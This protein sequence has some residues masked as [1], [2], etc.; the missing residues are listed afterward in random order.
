MRRSL[1]LSLGIHGFIVDPLVGEFSLFVVP[2]S[3]RYGYADGSSISSTSW[4][5]GGNLIL[6]PRGTYRLFLGLSQ[7]MYDTSRITSEDPTALSRAPDHNTTM[8][9]RFSIHGGALRG[10]ALMASRN[11]LEFVDSSIDSRI[12]ETQ[13][14]SWNRASLDFK[15]R[16]VLT[17]RQNDYGT[18]SF[19]SEDLILT[20][21]ENG[22][23]GR[24]WTWDGSLVGRE[25]ST[26]TGSDA[27]SY[28]TARLFNRFVKRY[29]QR[30]STLRISQSY[31]GNQP[32]ATTTTH[33][34]G[35]SVGYQTPISRAFTVAAGGGYST[36]LGGKS[37]LRAPQANGSISWQRIRRSTHLSFTG[38]ASYANVSR[39]AESASTVENSFGAGVSGSLVAGDPSKI[40]TSLS[41]GWF[42]SDFQLTADI[43]P[44]LP[45]LWLGISRASISDRTSARFTLERRKSAYDV[46]LVSNWNS[47]DSQ[48]EG[49]MFTGSSSTSSSQSLSIRVY[50]LNLGLGT[51][52]TD[53]KG[54]DIPV[55][56]STYRVGSV[57][58]SPL[59]NLHL[60]GSYRTDLRDF[61]SGRIDVERADITARF[62]IGQNQFW[63][64]GYQI[65]ESAG[66]GVPRRS[67]GW[68]ISL[69]R[70]FRGWLPFVSAV[71]GR[72]TIR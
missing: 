10:L 15:H 44:D 2:R 60:T 64:Q 57:T 13:T 59:K 43:D 63:V 49:E 21:Q 65:T 48:D 7:S 47:S 71:T 11:T 32:N 33:G 28:R 52:H 68:S 4:R 5:F 8:V 66:A 16:Y 61:P 69:S 41:A 12:T 26:S 17:H 45:D 35:L 37:R 22:N 55:I 56:S 36:E 46:R 40:E 18:N 25:R 67:R 1:G 6:F 39:T 23:L 27:R 19:Q 38:S 9:G 34:L 54:V 72:G 24:R 58:F 29:D 14:V 20:G 70:G 3:D 51:G 50:R 42:R 62:N 53:V 30:G 31:A